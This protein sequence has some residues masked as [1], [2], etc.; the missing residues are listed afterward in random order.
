M[1]TNFIKGIIVPILTPIDNNEV[2]DEA[3]L[4]KQVDFVI[5]GGVRGILAFG[6]NGE[7]YML[8]EREM[9]RTLEVIV[10]QANRRV[11]VYC[12]IGSIS[13]KACV[14]M[15][16]RAQHHKVDGISILQPMFL[17]PTAD[18]LYTHFE[19]IAKSV[20]DMPVLLY[21]NPR[22]G[23]TI[24]A[25]VVE[26][27]A[28]NVDNIVGMKDSSG[29]MT[30]TAEF[31]R[32]TRD[33]D[34]KVLGGKDTLIFGGLVHGAAGAVATMANFVP[35]LVTSIY[36]KFVA[37]DIKGALE[38]Q[39]TLMPIRLSM[40]KASFPVGTKDMAN[41]LG[42][43]VGLPYSPNKAT[44]GNA[45]ENMKDELKKAHLLK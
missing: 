37:G 41:L 3:K 12:G 25:D 28:R 33:I 2:V 35:E 30:Q 31:L 24:P 38:Q 21:N 27:L 40:D 36:D 10:S 39:Y 7:F 34:F 1:E 22:V 6:S 18:E 8:D 45:L 15:A 5:D 26:K 14:N 44:K 20:P 17:K 13:T 23:Y 9:E 32:R 43:D 29:D 19:R 11:P 42:M 16:K 4:R